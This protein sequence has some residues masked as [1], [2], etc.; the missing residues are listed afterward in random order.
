MAEVNARS[1]VVEWQQ[2]RV[3]RPLS[4][5]WVVPTPVVEDDQERLARRVVESLEEEAF[6]G[7]P[8]AVV[9][10]VLLWVELPQERAQI[11]REPR[12][13]GC[14]GDDV[15]GLLAGPKDVDPLDPEAVRPSGSAKALAE[16]REGR[17]REHPLRL[18]ARSPLQRGVPLPEGARGSLLRQEGRRGPGDLAPTSEVERT[19]DVL[20]CCRVEGDGGAS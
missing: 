8:C 17:V 12:R 19:L 1:A 5:A 6:V 10:G 18:L 4:T 11:T 15:G 20:G 9:A 16:Q 7:P 13:V 14:S 2:L 3:G